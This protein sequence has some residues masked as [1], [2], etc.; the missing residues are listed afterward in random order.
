MQQ[1]QRLKSLDRFKKA[2]ND[3]EAGS[4]ESAILVC[5]DVAARGLD[6]PYVGNVLHYQCPFNAEVYVHRCGRTARIGRT[7]QSL[8]LL[9]PDDSKAFKSICQVLK[10]SEDSIKMYQVKYAVLEKVRPLI[11]QAKELEKGIHQRK[12]SEKSANW[13]VKSAQEAD[14]EL[15]D[16]LQYELQ[17]QLGAKAAKVAGGSKQTKSLFDQFKNDG[18]VHRKRESK[19]VMRQAELKKKYDREMQAQK[20]KRFSNSSFLTPEAARYLNEA[21]KD[22]QTRIDE[23]VIYAGL[24]DTKAGKMKFKRNE[25]FS[26]K[27]KKERQSKRKRK[28]RF[29]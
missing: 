13:M 3:I 15:D 20:L 26:S 27:Y 19:Q 23:E 5:T 2:V 21:I 7:G 12:Q 4:K 28:G 10:K 29:G 9:A 1:K 8:A 16:E 25:Q 11:T 24:H 18:S 17:E 14:L 22:N 6:V